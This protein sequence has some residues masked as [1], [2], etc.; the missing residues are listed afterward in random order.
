MLKD[1]SISK[2]SDERHSLVLPGFGLAGYVHTVMAINF[3]LT[4]HAP[5]KNYYFVEHSHMNASVNNTLLLLQVKANC[6]LSLLIL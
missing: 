2:C 3:N 5:N 1:L 4:P 6:Y